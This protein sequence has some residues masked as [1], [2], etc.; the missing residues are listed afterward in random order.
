MG[1]NVI[2]LTD[3]KYMAELRQRLRDDFNEML[4]KR[5]RHR[6]VRHG[7]AASAAAAAAVAGTLFPLS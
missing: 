6:E 4:L 2:R 7:A 5:I 3:R 1:S